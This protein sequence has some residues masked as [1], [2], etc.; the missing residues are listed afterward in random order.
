MSEHAGLVRVGRFHPASGQRDETVIHL[1][2]MAAAAGRAPG[3]FGAQVTMSDR[4]P[5][6][7][8]LISRWESPDAL[9][10]FADQTE[11]ADIRAKLEPTLTSPPTFELF[12]TA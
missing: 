9:Q 8:V 11:F 3:C 7:L 12:T 5:D 1:N 2:A 6:A 10:R 4:D